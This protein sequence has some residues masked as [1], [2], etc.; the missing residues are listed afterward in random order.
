M[1][2]DL[3]GG[4]VARQDK[5]RWTRH[6]NRGYQAMIPIVRKTPAPRELIGNV[7][8]SYPDPRCLHF[9]RE[10]PASGR[11][12]TCFARIVA[13]VAGRW[14]ELMLQCGKKS[15]LAGGALNSARVI[16]PV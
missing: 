12:V 4:W 13:D 16:R 1:S 11:R 7:R 2:S 14:P 5:P 15:G 9:S 8:S 3:P 10:L 6:D